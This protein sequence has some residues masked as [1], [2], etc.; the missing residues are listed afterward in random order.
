MNVET[1]IISRITASPVRCDTSDN[2]CYHKN[3]VEE[4]TR[5]I[6]S[7]ILIQRTLWFLGK[8]FFFLFSQW[9]LLFNADYRY[10]EVQ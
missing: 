2:I 4:H 10:F 5:K 7:W 8:R 1:Y 6:H 3:F 9:R